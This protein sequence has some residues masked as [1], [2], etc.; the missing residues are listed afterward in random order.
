MR[1]I[2]NLQEK[3]D[4]LM[5]NVTI[6]NSEDIIGLSM[7]LDRLI[8]KYYEKSGINRENNHGTV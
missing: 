4:K 6:V 2:R 5:F 3:L 8:V 1:E 7:E